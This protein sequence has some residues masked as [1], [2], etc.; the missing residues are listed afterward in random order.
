M[1]KGVTTAQPPALPDLQECVENVWHP[2]CSPPFLWLP[3]RHTET[4]HKDE[5]VD[6]AFLVTAFSCSS[7]D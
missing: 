4:L 7:R 6:E 5:P 2:W 1:G 3:P